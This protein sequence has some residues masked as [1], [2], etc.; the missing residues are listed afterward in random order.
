MWLWLVHLQIFNFRE[1]TLPVVRIQENDVGSIWL[2]GKGSMSSVLSVAH[3]PKRGQRVS[4]AV[5]WVLIDT[6]CL[7]HT[8]AHPPV[9]SI[10]ISFVIHISSPMCITYVHICAHTWVHSAQMLLPTRSSAPSNTNLCGVKARRVLL[11]RTWSS[12]ASRTF[13]WRSPPF[14]APG[15]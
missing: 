8:C 12:S 11:V 7:W 3:G 2:P 1:C 10:Y 5:S 9:H 4:Y 14:L 15:V 13:A 6:F